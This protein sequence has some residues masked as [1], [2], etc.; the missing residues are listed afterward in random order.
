MINE[1]IQCN[2]S[3]QKENLVIYTW[4]NVSCREGK[5]IL[6]KPSGVKFDDLSKE[7]IS[8][9]DISSEDLISGYKPSVDT[10]TH[11]HLYK[12]FRNINAV[13]HT[14]SKYATIFAQAKKPIPCLGTTHAD[15]FYGDIPLVDDLSYD[16][17]ENNYEQNTGKKIVQYFKKNSIDPL[18][19]GAALCPSHGVFTWGKDLSSAL[20]NAIV[21]E[22]IAEVAYKTLVLNPEPNFN[23]ELLDKHFL[24]KHGKKSYYGQ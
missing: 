2:Q 19:M 14:H 10:P 15:Y 16:E 22:Y 18:N 13:V 4:G 11:I 5:Y 8:K 17:I 23:N 7:N 20:K 6:I 24:R 21:L 3:L 9:I 1:L 12:N